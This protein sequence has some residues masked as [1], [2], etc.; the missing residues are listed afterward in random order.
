MVW[1]NRL[2]MFWIFVLVLL[3]VFDLIEP[4]TVGILLLSWLVIGVAGTVIGAGV[5]K[6]KYGGW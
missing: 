4:A 2:V 1:V 5:I 6:F 3:V